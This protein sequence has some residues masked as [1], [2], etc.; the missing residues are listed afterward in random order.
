MYRIRKTI[1]TEAEQI[2]IIPL[3]DLHYP[4][5]NCNLK[6]FQETIDYIKSAPATCVILMGDLWDCVMPQDTR[7]DPEGKYTF[8]EEAYQTIKNILLPVKDRVICCLQG[9]HEYKLHSAGYADITKRLADELGADYAGFSA[10]IKIKVMPKTHNSSLTI[11]AHHG[12]S[13]GRKTGGTINAIENLSQYYDADIYLM[14]HSHKLASTKQV[15]IDW[16][17]AKDVLFCNTGTFLETATWDKTGY[18][19]RAGYPP[20]RLGCLKIKYYPKKHK[21]YCTE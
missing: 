5:P 3:G 14:G 19:E 17:G 7:F 16:G 6:K 1:T 11:Y 10:F 12:F 4:S 8:I 15:R 18:S 21:Y 9:N 13:A 20:L 2:E